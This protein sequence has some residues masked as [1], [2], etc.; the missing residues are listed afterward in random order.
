MYYTY[1][2]LSKVDGQFYTG[3]T[4]NLKRRFEEHNRGRVQS[5]KRRKP[6]DL[7]YYEACLSNEDAYRRE[8]YLKTGKGKRY[9]RNRLKVALSKI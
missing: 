1:V 6:L 5:T 2:L 7:I 3:C 9:I 8:R 4:D